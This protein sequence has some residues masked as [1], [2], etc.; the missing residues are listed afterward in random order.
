MARLSGPR[1]S[2]TQHC[3][4]CQRESKIERTTKRIQRDGK[5][6][7]FSAGKLFLGQKKLSR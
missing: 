6:E 4:D 3:G 2:R 7:I 1:L 5:L